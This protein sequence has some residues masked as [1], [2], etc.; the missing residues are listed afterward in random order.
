MRGKRFKAAVQ[1]V[2]DIKGM[3]KPVAWWVDMHEEDSETEWDRATGAPARTR[4][5]QSNTRLTEPGSRNSSTFTWSRS[6]TTTHKARV[7]LTWGDHNRQAA[8]P[9]R[10]HRNRKLTHS[11]KQHKPPHSATHNAAAHPEGTQ[12]GGEQAAVTLSRRTFGDAKRVEGHLNVWLLSLGVAPDSYLH[13][14]DLCSGGAWTGVM[15]PQPDSRGPPYFTDPHRG[16]TRIRQQPLPTQYNRPGFLPGVALVPFA[17][18]MP[19]G[20]APD[21]WLLF[22]SAVEGQGLRQATSARGDTFVLSMPR[23]TKRWER[24]AVVGPRAPSSTFTTGDV[25]G[26]STREQRTCQWARNC[27][28]L[29]GSR[30]GRDWCHDRDRG[31]RP[32]HLSHHGRDR[33]TTRCRRSGG[34]PGQASSSTDNTP[35]QGCLAF[36]MARRALRRLVTIFAA[37]TEVQLQGQAEQLLLLLDPQGPGGPANPLR[38]VTKAT[39]MA[40]REWAET[41]TVG[42]ARPRGEPSP[43]RSSRGGNSRE[44]P[45]LCT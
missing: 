27:R 36:A 43:G 34:D 23:G 10:H 38:E 26:R 25:S 8:P 37:T 7:L 39:D 15:L 45:A 28:L 12:E 3:A 4:S 33:M 24:K 17:V 44:S 29:T 35:P 14:R 16:F 6:H 2:F 41:A 19:R 18:G 1:H 32:Q 13:L 11:K 42:T 5:L 9:T 31:Q 30:W 40:A 22:I 20:G 21:R